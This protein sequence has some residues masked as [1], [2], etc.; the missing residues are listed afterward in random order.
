MRVRLICNFFIAIVAIIMFLTFIRALSEAMAGDYSGVFAFAL[1]F[2]LL[3]LIFWA[4]E[5]DDQDRS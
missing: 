3:G 4:V 2:G 5:K 1:M